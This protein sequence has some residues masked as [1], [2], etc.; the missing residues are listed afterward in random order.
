M[1]EKRIFLNS[2][3]MQ[4]LPQLVRYLS[5]DSGGETNIIANDSTDAADQTNVRGLHLV[6]DVFLVTT[7]EHWN[8]T[9]PG[10]IKTTFGHK[11]YRALLVM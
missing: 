11:R 4:S 3:T 6:F 2:R 9:I 10:M 1:H 8:R 5:I 7:G